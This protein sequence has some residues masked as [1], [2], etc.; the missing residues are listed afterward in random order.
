MPAAHQRHLTRRFK[1]LQCERAQ[2]LQHGEAW[3]A[4]GSTRLLHQTV[5]D[6]HRQAIEE[7]E[8]MHAVRRSAVSDDTLELVYFGT[9]QLGSLKCA[10]AGKHAQP[11]KQR[12]RLSLQ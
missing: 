5:V 1:L 4:V 11:A 6:Q 3:L 7:A 2:S 10:A 12:L 8:G 9:D